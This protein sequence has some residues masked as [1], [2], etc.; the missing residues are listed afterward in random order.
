M[1]SMR[2]DT[3][4][5]E[6]HAAGNT[7]PPARAKL[8]GGAI[9]LLFILVALPAVGA[10]LAGKPLAG[11]LRFPPQ[12]DFVRHA[13][14]SW[15]AF[16]GLALVA[17][18]AL[19]PT[20]R[21]LLARVPNA[22]ARSP[23]AR[24]FP[25]WG[26]AGLV[27]GGVAW[28]VAWTR[29][30]VFSSIQRF[31]FTPLWLSYVVMVNALRYRRDG[32]CMMLDRPRLFLWLFPPSAAFW[33]FFEYLNGFVH[34]WYYLGVSHL[35][36]FEYFLLA[37]LPFST[38]LPAVLC[39][40]ELLDTPRMRMRGESLLRARLPSPGIAAAALLAFSC[41][42]LIGIG[43]WPEVLFPLVWV[44]P[45]LILTAVQMLRRTSGAPAPAPAPEVRRK[46]LLMP[47]AAAVCGFFW[48]MWNYYSLA[49][50]K[51]EIPYVG[52]FHI[53]EM[54]LLGY[55]GYLPFGWECALIGGFIHRLASPEKA[56][57]RHEGGD[58]GRSF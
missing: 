35:S 55:L 14:F 10:V 18:V 22:P 17:G 38:V 30:P 26:W 54:P 52:G 25:W 20:A 58:P 39:T 48:E 16:L 42:S 49:K 5:G 6:A 36:S 45:A 44:A 28:I 46:I 12:A 53:F 51:Y 50:W 23:R 32:R 33:W 31:T 27:L 3:G 13:A 21:G 56:V 24:P 2:D 7:P 37:T 34:S 41:M 15:P 29:F 19:A 4:T 9:L 40:Y 11:Y 1:G 57:S 47:L 8:L 43:V